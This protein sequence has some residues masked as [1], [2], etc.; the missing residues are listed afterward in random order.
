[1]VRN[2]FYKTIHRQGPTAVQHVVREA[3]GALATSPGHSVR[4]EPIGSVPRFSQEFVS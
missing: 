4:T 1:M 3:S 2:F